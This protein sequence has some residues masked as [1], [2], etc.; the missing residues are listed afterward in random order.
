MSTTPAAIFKK[1]AQI[2]PSIHFDVKYD[3][4]PHFRWDGDGPDLREEGFEAYDVT[5]SA[6]TIVGGS[7]RVGTQ[8]LSGHY[9]IPGRH[10]R[11]LGGYLPQML[12]EAVDELRKKRLPEPVATQARNAQEYLRQVFKTRYQR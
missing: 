7:S 3:R 8:Y 5:V 12:E 4:D 10:D 9:D 2:A 11:D 1:L 6:H